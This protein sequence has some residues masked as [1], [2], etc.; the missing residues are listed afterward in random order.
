MNWGLHG[1]SEHNSACA[2][3]FSFIFVAQCL[4]HFARCG[5]KDRET[6]GRVSCSMSCLSHCSGLRS[7]RESPRI[8]NGWE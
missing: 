8:G 4:K 2:F 1:L 7:Q 5:R 6:H 3:K